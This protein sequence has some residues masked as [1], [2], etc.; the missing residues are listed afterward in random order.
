ML[1]IIMITVYK[2]PIQITDTQTVEMP[3]GAQL[4]HVGLDPLGTPCVWAKVRSD[5]QTEEREIH[6]YGTG[7][8]MSG[9]AYNHVGSFC[10][11]PFVWHVFS[12]A[13]Y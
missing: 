12:P 13:K 2:Y 8:R 9:Q 1:E 11:G 10:Q 3:I 7:H 4:I 5:S 6:V